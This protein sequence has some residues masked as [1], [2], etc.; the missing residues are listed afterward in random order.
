MSSALENMLKA[1]KGI[2]INEKADETKD[3]RYYK[4]DGTPRKVNK[5]GTL[6][7]VNI[8]GRPKK[9]I[10]QKKVQYCVRMLPKMRQELERYC[11]KAGITINQ[12]VEF[13]IAEF[14]SNHKDN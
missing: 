5:D 6:K 10:E 7:S 8:H 12:G 3:P 9:P 13:A 11:L 2:N 1:N 14:L 4:P